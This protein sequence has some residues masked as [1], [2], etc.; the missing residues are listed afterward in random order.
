MYVCVDVFVNAFRSGRP[1]SPGR[2]KLL[3]QETLGA[4]SAIYHANVHQSPLG[5]QERR[6]LEDLDIIRECW[7]TLFGQTGSLESTE[8]IEEVG[9]HV[10]YNNVIHT[11]I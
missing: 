4:Q 5:A 6:M 3:P 10:T 9:T 11:F 8:E 1:W 7:Q 2:S